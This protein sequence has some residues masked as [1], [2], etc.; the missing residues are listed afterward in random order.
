MAKRKGV[1]GDL[2]LRMLCQLLLAIS[3]STKTTAGSRMLG[4]VT[5]PTPMPKWPAGE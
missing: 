5:T 1:G 3:M 4:C 2:D